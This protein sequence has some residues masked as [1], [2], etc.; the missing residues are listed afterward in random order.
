MFND[1]GDF[2]CRGRLKSKD[3]DK[4]TESLLVQFVEIE[5]DSCLVYVIYTTNLFLHL[6]GLFLV[7][8]F[9]CDLLFLSQ[10]KK[11]MEDDSIDVS[12]V[13]SNIIRAVRAMSG[14]LVF[15]CSFFYLY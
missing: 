12:N 3:K 9:I 8:N 4:L 11:N 13:I 2:E 5:S 14:E 10:D 15:F 6:Y 7:S 1:K